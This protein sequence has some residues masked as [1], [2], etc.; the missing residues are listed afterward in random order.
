MLDQLSGAT[1]L[2]PI[3][4]DPIKYVESPVR[5]TRTF[6]ERGYHGICVP[7][8][9][10][11]EDLDAVM[12]GLTASRNVDGIL[13]T[14]PHK[15][16]AFGY[17]A[18]SSERARMLGVVSVIRR[19]PDGTWHGDM[20]DGLAFVKTQVDHG[21]EPA[22]ARVLLVGAGGAGSAIAI[23]MLEAGVRELIVHD[24]DESRVNA[25]LE[26][27][28]D[29]GRGRVIAGP[30]DPT[31]CDLVCNATPM[32]MEAGDPLPVD[33]ALLTSSMFVGDVISGHGLTPF[34][35]A[36]KAAGCK[37]ADGGHMVEAAQDVMADFFQR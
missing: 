24:A 12:A 18:T 3:I 35:A 20:L 33:P 5:L 25:L 13:V 6:G 27:V 28:A 14:M 17:C 8:Q 1:R 9:V 37:T 29:L 4:G 36:A 19:N 21:A 16:T 32:G 26:L 15:F 10:P 23:A 30:P 22:G 11:A 31:G 2:F 7:M 34:L